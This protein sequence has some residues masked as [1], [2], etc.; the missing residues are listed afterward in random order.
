M[1]IHCEH[2]GQEINAS[3]CRNIENYQVGRIVCPSCRHEQKRYISEADLLLYFGI[4]E[5]MYVGMSLLMVAI[6]R[7]WGVSWNSAFVI[8]F[9]IIL[10][11]L[12]SKEL[13]AAIYQKAFF[14]KE[15][16]NKVFS[17]DAKAIQKNI[18]WQFML[19]FAITITFLTVKEGRLFFAIAMPLAVLLTFVKFFLQIRNE[20]NS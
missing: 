10:S 16:K 13:A 15:W 18:S 8:L 20:R 11:F 19:F 12:L 9:L 7:Y 6:F 5:A 4:S 14:K 17:E 1:K 3:C 2:C